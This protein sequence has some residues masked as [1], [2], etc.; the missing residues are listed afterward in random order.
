V[1]EIL[2]QKKILS[3]ERMGGKKV[4]ELFYNKKISALYLKRFSKEEERTSRPK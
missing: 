1:G 2:F 4:R 3:S